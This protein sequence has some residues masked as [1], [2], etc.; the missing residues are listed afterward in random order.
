M[1]NILVIEDNTRMRSALTRMLQTS[2]HRVTA[3][4]NGADGLRLW[5]E[6]GAD[7]VLT[8]IQM[9]GMSGIDVMLQLRAHAPM[10]PVLA[11]SAAIG[12]GIWICSGR[13]ACSAPLAYSRSRSP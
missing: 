5:H 7:L 8:D 13:S 1:P 12:P 9:P 3:A 10:V 11:M 4:A 6:H 2:G